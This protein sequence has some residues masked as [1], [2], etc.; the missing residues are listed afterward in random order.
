MRNLGSNLWK[1][2]GN[3]LDFGNFLQ[4]FG[5]LVSNFPALYEHT[6]DTPNYK[7]L[8]DQVNVFVTQKK[9]SHWQYLLLTWSG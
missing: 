3:F 2:G 8:G 4:L 7:N 5:T 6:R 9:F 1:L